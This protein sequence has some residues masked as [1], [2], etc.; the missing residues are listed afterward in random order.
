ML[1]LEIE[2]FPDKFLIAGT[3]NYKDYWVVGTKFLQQYY[4]VFDRTDNSI[5]FVELTDPI[6]SHIALIIIIIFT[7]VFFI[8]VIAYIR[9][10]KLK[11]AEEDEDILDDTKTISAE[12][13]WV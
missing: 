5:S 4:T 3:S 9:C 6:D 13:E 7:A 12:S 11:S 2:P 8:A 1:K 10:K